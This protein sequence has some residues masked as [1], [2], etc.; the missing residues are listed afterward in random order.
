MLMEAP[1][2]ERKLAA[3]LA[4]DV[5][6]YSRLMHADEEATLATL[7]AHRAI[8]DTLIAAGHGRI[9]GTAGDSVLAE[10]ASVVDAVHCAVA[11]QQALHK[12]NAG[13]PQER[14]MYLRI[15]INVGDV[16]VKDG[17]LFGDGVNVA[18]RLE[19][20]AEPG[21]ICITRGV[22]DHVQDRVDYGFED[23]GEQ[24]VKNIAR[25]VR[26]LRMIFDTNGVTELLPAAGGRTVRDM[27][28]EFGSGASSGTAAASEETALELAFWTSVQASDDP[29]EYKAYLERYPEGT[30]ATLARAR[31]DSPSIPTVAP[32]DRQVEL[33]FWDTV[34]GS[35]NPAMLWAYLDRF[36][37]GE[38]RV[39]A[40]L[41]LTELGAS[42]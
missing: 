17:D 26:V 30:F 16:M 6:G 40:E 22:R 20:L 21:G 36:P 28:P 23:L 3:I 4:A 24:A 15:G 25:P 37:D 41:R 10:F 2:L 31:L 7:T 34:K 27:A 11:I 39:L 19:A 38:F 32:E 13:L 33:A 1:P 12:A 8:I 9:S 14:R 42:S 29:L 18:A 5:E 35:D